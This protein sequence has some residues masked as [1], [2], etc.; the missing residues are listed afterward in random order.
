MGSA[1]GVI[2]TKDSPTPPPYTEA[3]RPSVDKALA[4]CAD[5]ARSEVL[6][7][8]TG[9]RSPTDDE[10]NEQVSVDRQGNPVTRAMQWGQEMHASAFK[11]AEKKLSALRPG[12]YSIEPRYRYDSKTGQTT[13]LSPE[14]VEALL[15]QGRGGELLGTLVP[16]IVIHNGT[17]LL[18]MEVYD[19]KFPCRNTDDIPLWRRYKQGPYA[20]RSQGD[21]YKEA[22]RLMGKAA[23]VVPRQG[24]IR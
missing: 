10:C 8:R 5:Q 19:F 7:R 3:M 13:Y 12:G 23:R 24:V 15:R 20:P 17:P 9:G 6:L 18:V 2:A 21:I 4:E 16:D 22:L 1:L 11:C 14:E